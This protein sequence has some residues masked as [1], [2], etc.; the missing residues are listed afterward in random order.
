[1]H[2]ERLD[3]VDRLL[4]DHYSPRGPGAALLILHRGVP[5]FLHG[6]GCAD[7]LAF[8]SITPLS[9]FDLASAGKHFAAFSILL[10][11]SRGQ[12]APSDPVSR[13]LPELSPLDGR[14]RR[15]VRIQDLMQHSS[16]LPEYLDSLQESNY[17][18]CDNEYVVEW[19]AA[20]SFVFEPGSQGMILEQSDTYCN[21][22]Y[23]LLA[24]IIER[25]SSISYPNFLQSRLFSPLGMNDSFCTTSLEPRPRQVSRYDANARPIL[26]P[27]AIPVYGDGSVYSTLGDLQRWFA[28]Q[29]QPTLIDKGLLEAALAGGLLDDGTQT[30][31]G[32]GWYS[33][34]WSGRRAVWHSGGWDG[35][36]TCLSRWIDD[37]V[38][39][40][41]L[42]N[43]RMH[44]PTAIVES[45]EKLLLD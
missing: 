1:M 45:I 17:E 24:S 33:R 23:A 20:Q 32:A 5:V 16:G 44:G 34:N 13:H 4:Q 22:N 38:A 28:E 36:A 31:Y 43:T 37:Q 15:P 21:T 7:V 29:D 41:L 40:I 10:L 3:E 42:S 30:H 11:A 25:V 9:I 12:L 26:Q 18:Q 2:L 8:R 6:Y 35:A 14:S 19:V 27:R 39:I